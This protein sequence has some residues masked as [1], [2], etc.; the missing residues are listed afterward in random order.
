MLFKFGRIMADLFN[1]DNITVLVIVTTA[2]TS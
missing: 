1:L 2:A